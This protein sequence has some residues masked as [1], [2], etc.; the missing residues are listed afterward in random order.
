MTCQSK[1]RLLKQIILKNIN[2]NL[3]ILEVFFLKAKLKKNINKK[4]I[5]YIDILRIIACFC[6][7]INHTQGFLLEK[8]GFGNTLFYCLTFSFCKVGVVLFLMISGMLILDKDYSCVNVS[9]LETFSE[10]ETI[11][12]GPKLVKSKK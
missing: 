1:K 3:E 2:I 4:E 7:I 5:I 6:V 10:Q 12:E 9:S 11:I 8:G